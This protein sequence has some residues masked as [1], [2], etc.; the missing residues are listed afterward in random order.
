[1]LVLIVLAAL[2]SFA[3]AGPALSP[4]GIYAVKKE[5]K[6]AGKDAGT[7]ESFYSSAEIDFESR[8]PNDTSGQPLAATHTDQ[9]TKLKK[10][11]KLDPKDPAAPKDGYLDRM[12]MTF[13]RLVNVTR[14]QIPGMARPFEARADAGALLSGKP[15][16]LRGDGKTPKKIDNLG[17]VKS[18][19][20]AK[21]SDPMTRNTLNLLLDEN[22]LLPMGAS[23]AS[24][25]G[26]CLDGIAGKKPGEKWG[27]SHEEQGA[28]L[29][30]SCAFEGWAEEGGHKIEVIKLHSPK[31][32]TVRTQP[33]GVPGMVE[34]ESDGVIYA[35]PASHEMVS[36]A[37]T[38]INAEPMPE[39][40]ER[41]K[42]R[43]QAVPRNRSTVKTVTH[44][45]GI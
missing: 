26:T 1:M 8:D 13:E 30:F 7:P 33:N 15:L 16:I 25:G 45:Y 24:S 19:A 40:L 12:E 23:G 38:T 31:T 10:L 6:D 29:D 3:H 39:E 4:T 20:M 17:A 42:A 44:V 21:A 43:G 28:K 34:T 36:R 22:R 18:G 5:I 27:Y 32:K 37:D 9:L 11:P 14:A 2:P 41:L 35:D